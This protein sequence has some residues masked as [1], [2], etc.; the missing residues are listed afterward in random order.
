MRRRLVIAL[1]LVVAVLIVGTVG[2]VVVER[3]SWLDA[4][5]M[6]VITV[7]T[8]GFREVQPLSDA[9]KVLTIVL[10][11]GGVSAIAFAFATTLDF[12]LEGHLKGFL[13]EKR[14]NKL[15]AGLSQ[16]HIVAGMGR[17]GSEV[18]RSFAAEGVPFV[19]IDNCPDCVQRATAEGWPVLEAD[20]TEEA[21]LRAAGIER[22]SSLVT[23]LDTDAA[24][25]FVALTA[26]TLNP[27][28]FIVARSSA[29]SSEDKLMRA[30]ADRV[31]TPSVI[32]GIRMASM[33]LHPH[34]SQYVDL[35]DKAGG[36]MRLEEVELAE[37][38][39]LVGRTLKDARITE[40]TGVFVL[41]MRSRDGRV[42]ATPASDTM[43]QAGTRMVVMGS[44]G[45]LEK[46]ATSL[47]GAA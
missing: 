47:S 26:R 25:V 31:I 18:A 44:V 1:A 28:L 42:A 38:S 19:V 11:L 27:K 16:H 2:Y 23:A 17:V 35:F 34:V 13:E 24:N 41:A 4:L 32:G 15:L 37:D 39:P 14:M 21:A 6:T 12:L 9:G 22:A 3:W 33:V 36:E 46:L 43:L 40:R 8:V 5:Y 45:Q 10:V 30:G 29:S 7:G 20:A